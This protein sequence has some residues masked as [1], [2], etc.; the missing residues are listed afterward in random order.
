MFLKLAN[1]CAEKEGATEEEVNELLQDKPASAKG[2][3]CVRAC[4]AETIGMVWIINV[5]R[6]KKCLNIFWF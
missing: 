2:G 5:I 3:K 6:Y 4:L 1:E